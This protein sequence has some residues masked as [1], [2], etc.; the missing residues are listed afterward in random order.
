MRII[1][2][3]FSRT[4]RTTKAPG[5]PWATHCSGL[6]VVLFDVGCEASLLSFCVAAKVR[7]R[8]AGKGA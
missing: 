8:K 5:G 3:T 7:C 1:D 6:S 2:L 4:T